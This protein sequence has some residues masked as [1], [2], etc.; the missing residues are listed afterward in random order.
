MKILAIVAAVIGALLLFMLA[1]ASANSS[2]FAQHY[3]WL[4]GINALIA[5]AL[6]ALVGARLWRL[7]K[8]YRAGAFG[9]RL[10]VRF[11]LM[12]AVMA[13][14]PGV[15]VYAVSMQFAI[16]SI[17]SWFDVRVDRAL[18]GGLALGRSVI[19]AQQ[20]DML[21]KG[22]GLTLELADSNYVSPT[23]FARLRERSG[24]DGLVLFSLNGTALV[25]ST[26]SDQSLLPPLPSAAQIRQARQ[27]RGFAVAEGDAEEGLI[28][29][30][31]LP[32]FGMDGEVR[33][34]QL[35][36]KVPEYL[37]RSAA[38]VESAHRDYQ[39]LQFGKGGLKRI[40]TLTLTLALL[41]ALFAAIALAFYLAERLVKPLLILAE[42]TQAVA[43]GDFTPRDQIQSSD[44]L[45]V[46]TRSFNQMTRQLDD[47]RREA[48]RQRALNEEARTYLESV[49]GNLSA[50]VIAFD[51]DFVMRAANLG[52]ISILRNDLV[53]VEQVPLAEWPHHEAFALGILDGFDA[54]SSDWQQQIELTSESGLHQTLLVRGT[55]LPALSG[56]GYV[57][58]FDDITDLLSAQRTAAWGEVARRLA[59]EIKNP[60]TPI[61][62]SAERLQ[63]KL[64]DKVD[65]ASREML[66]RATQTIVNQVEA[67]KSLVNEFRDYARTPPPVLA[68]VDLNALVREVLGLYEN[69]HAR[70]VA[71]LDPDMPKV[72]ADAN[73]MRQVIHNLLTNAQDV[74][75]ETATETARIVIAT[76]VGEHLAGLTVS[77]N[78]NGFPPQILAHAFEPYVTTKAKGTGLGL[79]IVKKIVDDHGGEIRLANREGGGAEISI[80]LR[81][82]SA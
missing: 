61:Q 16:K 36:D 65:E 4:L 10:K 45:G 66:D 48:D 51:D 1:S 49:L 12:L 39:E 14:L 77:D 55:T 57:V 33:I 56:G 11:M 29:R 30:V 17:E 2:L 7:W 15:L 20:N 78:G 58:V 62:L 52:A 19:E 32:V 81:T 25:S 68:P 64:A 75:A 53:S 22:R 3:P 38:S 80:Q 37:A 79:A 54:H 18:E 73:Q 59:H 31:L 6:V 76:H 24:V 43:S 13:L 5:L 63:I 46:L 44:E 70:V 47:A 27:G 41:L 82:V 50:G 67:L 21:E 71:D 72:L 35:T 40:Y 60:L 9:S 26:A 74:L 23:S 8:E 42:G 69:A 34:L 28:L